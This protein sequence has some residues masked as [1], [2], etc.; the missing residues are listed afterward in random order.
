MRCELVYTHLSIFTG[1]YFAFSQI[2]RF[3]TRIRIQYT[4]P[5]MDRSIEIVRQLEQVFQPHRTMFEEF[6]EEKK[7]LPTQ[8]FC[9]EKTDTKKY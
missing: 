6:K 5:S 9:K 7:Q 1:S 2:R 4:N 8:C 3:A